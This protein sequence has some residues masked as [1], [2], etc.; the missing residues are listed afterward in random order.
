MPC[1]GQRVLAGAAQVAGPVELFLERIVPA[2]FIDDGLQLADLLDAGVR[3]AVVGCLV[4][5][6]K[7]HPRAV[8]RFARPA[9]EHRTLFLL[10]GRHGIGFASLQRLR[11][12]A[13]RDGHGSNRVGGGGRLG[14]NE[15]PHRQRTAGT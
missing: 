9:P 12:R 7:G 10:G 8:R 4:H 3:V 13:L 15:T 14:R 5:A 2:Q 1:L 11:N 6:A